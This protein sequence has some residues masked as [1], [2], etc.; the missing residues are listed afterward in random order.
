MKYPKFLKEN[1]CIGV[2]AP[3]A[4]AT[5]STKQAKMQKAKQVLESYGYKL[6]LSDNLML[7][8]RGRSASAKIRGQEINAM[9][10]NKDI[11]MVM[12]AT[13]GDF[14]VEMLPYVDFELIK[15]NP[16]LVGGFSDPTGLLYPITTICDI[17]TI[18][19]HNFSSFGSNNLHKTHLDNLEILKGNIIPQHSY[20]LYEEIS[21]ETITGL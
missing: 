4:G 12:C 1:D 10:Q 21:P 2:P 6:I 8:E 15:Q 9:F 3:S 17:A 18:Y 16:K 13:G 7:G 14:L 19:G 5:K 20:D 11:D